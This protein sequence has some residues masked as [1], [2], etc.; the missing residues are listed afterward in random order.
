MPASVFTANDMGVL[1]AGGGAR[2][3]TRGSGA[4]MYVNGT[5]VASATISGRGVAGFVY[6]SAT[7]CYLTGDVS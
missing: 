1:I 4:A 3:V 7:V 6:E 2:T 5:N